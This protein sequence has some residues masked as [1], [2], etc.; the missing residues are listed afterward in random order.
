MGG[1]VDPS[2][3]GKHLTRRLVQ[4]G[5]QEHLKNPSVDPQEYVNLL[6][7]QHFACLLA[8]EYPGD[9]VIG[10]AQ[11]LRARFGSYRWTRDI[12]L[13]MP[14]D[15]NEEDF[16]RQ[17]E[18]LSSLSSIDFK[19]AGKVK[20]HKANEGITLGIQ[21][22]SNGSN[23]GRFKIDLSPNRGML[24]TETV[25]LPSPI[26]GLVVP[27]TI[28]AADKHLA[29][30]LST[31][32]P[33]VISRPEGDL[34]LNTHRYHDLVDIAIMSQHSKFNLRRVV[35]FFS[36]AVDKGGPRIQ[37]LPTLQLPGDDWNA[38]TWA[39]NR[40][41]KH[42]PSELTIDRALELATPLANRVLACYHSEFA[43]PAEVWLPE[44]RS[45]QPTM[46]KSILDALGLSHDSVSMDAIRRQNSSSDNP[47]PTHFMTQNDNDLEL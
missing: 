13:D 12:D 39:H 9:F 30:K 4:L 29:N 10:G 14:K 31:L 43:T 6:V 22:S 18:Y 46:D 26:S 11:A 40:Q 23:V 7:L 5:E 24:D 42:W 20:R 17:R 28:M 44:Q 25:S 21:A 16:K 45:W 33:R 41:L 37:V 15:F 47:G 8:S 38:E 36:E 34:Y 27:A 32:H 3:K 19:L 35:E 2:L 1:L